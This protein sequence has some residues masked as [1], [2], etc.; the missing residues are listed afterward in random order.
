MFL[1]VFILSGPQSHYY[2]YILNIIMYKT[3]K[4]VFHLCSSHDLR[5]SYLQNDLL[6]MTCVLLLASVAWVISC[7]NIFAV[8]IRCALFLSQPGNH[9]DE[10][11][12]RCGKRERK[13][14]SDFHWLK[15]PP[16][17]LIAPGARS[18]VC[19]LVWTIPW[20]WQKYACPAHSAHFI[21]NNPIGIVFFFACHVDY[22]KI[23]DTY[24]FIFYLTK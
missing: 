21:K 16:A 2:F 15:T 9:H 10:S 7:V 24:S 18:T 4:N 17:P 11:R 6:Y 20:Y 3:A 23:F 14:V 5:R 8:K 13:T 1:N 22:C 12:P 19:P